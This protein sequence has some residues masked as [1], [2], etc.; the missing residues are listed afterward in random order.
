MSHEEDIDIADTFLSRR[1]LTSFSSGMPIYAY[2]LA[3]CRGGNNA[4]WSY[5]RNMAGCQEDLPLPPL[6]WLRI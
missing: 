2:M 5:K 1:D 3:I 6:G 4:L